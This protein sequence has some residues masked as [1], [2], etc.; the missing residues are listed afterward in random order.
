[1]KRWDEAIQAFDSAI[2]RFDEVGSRLEQERTLYQRGIMRGAPG[3]TDTARADARRAYALLEECGAQVDV[4]KAKSLLKTLNRKSAPKL[5]AYVK[6]SPSKA[7]TFLACFTGVS[8]GSIDR[9]Y[10]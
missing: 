3:H 1:M 4:E 6:K 8:M 7:G 9:E 10:R 5:D 2:A